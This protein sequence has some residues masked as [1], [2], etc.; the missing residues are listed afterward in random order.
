MDSLRKAM[1]DAQREMRE[2]MKAVADA[3]AEAQRA[4]AHHADASDAVSSAQG[5]ARSAGAGLD[6]TA[7]STGG[8]ADAA[9]A[10]ATPAYGNVGYWDARYATEAASEQRFEWYVPYESLRARLRRWAPPATA[11]AVLVVGCGNSTLSE[12]MHADGYRR[13]VSVDNAPSVIEDM[14][15][16]HGHGQGG[17]QGGRAAGSDGGDADA[18]GATGSF[19]YVMDARQ[20]ALADGTFDLAVDKGTLDAML[21]G[22]DAAALDSAQRMGRDTM[23]VLRAG[24]SFVVVSSVAPAQYLPLLSGWCGGARNVEVESFSVG[25]GDGA[26]SA[27]AG[28]RSGENLRL[29]AY[30]LRKPPALALV[31]LPQGSAVGSGDELLQMARA[32]AQ[33]RAQQEQLERELAAARGDVATLSDSLQDSRAELCWAEQEKRRLGAAVDKLQPGLHDAVRGVAREGAALAARE[34]AQNGPAGGQSAGGGAG[35]AGRATVAAQAAAFVERRRAEATA[36]AAVEE[37]NAAR[38]H[39]LRAIAKYARGKDGTEGAEQEVGGVG[40]GG[41]AGPTPGS[42]VSPRGPCGYAYT[43]SQTREDVFVEVQ[44]PAGTRAAQVQCDIDAAVM[45][46][47]LA[48]GGEPLLEGHFPHSVRHR[49]CVWWLTGASLHLQLAKRRVGVAWERVLQGEPAIQ[50]GSAAAATDY[51]AVA[52]RIEQ[53]AGVG[54][55][56]ANDAAGGG[57]GH[58]VGAGPTAASDGRRC[59]LS[60]APPFDPALE[61]MAKAKAGVQSAAAQPKQAELRVAFHFEHDASARER[62]WIGVWLADDAGVVG[63]FWDSAYVE[64]DDVGGA[65][66][67]VSLRAPR[68]AALGELVVQYVAAGDAGAVLGARNAAAAAREAIARAER[69]AAAAQSPELE[70]GAALTPGSGGE[71]GQEESTRAPAAMAA[72][73]ADATATLTSPAEEPAY[74]LEHQTSINCFSLLV[75]LPAAPA[76]APA[77][78]PATKLSREKLLIEIGAGEA[79]P[80]APA[81]APNSRLEV[82]FAYDVSPDTCSMRLYGD[83]AAISLPAARSRRNG[84]FDARDPTPLPT[85]AELEPEALHT[86]R[87]RFCDEDLALEGAFANV[88]PLPSTHW[89]ELAEFCVFNFRVAIGS[90]EEAAA[91]LLG[92]G[93][94]SDGGYSDGRQQVAAAAGGG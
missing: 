29:Y 67:V 35:G 3:T 54:A 92:G 8:A 58:G 91:A 15:R 42:S 23:R 69:A 41:A 94:D 11:R 39:A 64:D 79:A 21:A 49:D 84:A 76:D 43:W 61:S 81:P 2:A 56:G 40:G 73:A 27:G 48:G 7:R 26:D 93:E 65:R 60:L 31:P 25:Y 30:R 19:Y 28:G 77:P 52:R 70:P 55:G 10:S 87:C 62:D 90:E 34:G 59:L 13:V 24:G 9:A 44:V 22:C 12:Q 83:H 80:P 71:A 63:R 68:G 20:L 51:V 1:E 14:R 89:A 32:Q 36:A 78:Q 85:P 50:P 4:A 75:H 38:R 47:S 66:G 46:L 74:V 16:Q 88:L 57:G 5:R 18:S 53:H 72:P 86:L 33:M 6:A 37:E 45:S 82:A 17:G